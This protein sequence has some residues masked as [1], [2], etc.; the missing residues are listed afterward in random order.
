MKKLFSFV[1]VLCLCAYAWAYDFQVDGLYYTIIN[2]AEEPYSVALTDPSN[3]SEYQNM[4]ELVIPEIVEYESKT[5]SVTRIDARAF[6][7]C[8]NLQTVSVPESIV[9]CGSG[10]FAECPNLTTVYWNATHCRYASNAFQGCEK[11]QS[12]E[13]GD[14]VEVLPYK[15]CSY[16]PALTTI[17]IPESVHS[18]NSDVF[19]YC[20]GLTEINWNA[21]KIDGRNYNRIFVECNNVASIDFGNT[22]EM[23]PNYL[24]YNMSKLQEVLLPK[25]IKRIG[26]Y[27][28]CYCTNLA[29]VFI[30]SSTKLE[31]IAPYAFDGTAWLENYPEGPM[32]IGTVLYKNKITNSRDFGFEVKAGTTY[33]TPYAFAQNYGLYEISLPASLAVLGDTALNITP[34][35]VFSGCYDLIA[36][37]VHEDNAHFTSV[38]GNLYT[39]D[40]EQLLYVPE[41]S[42]KPVVSVTV[43][44]DMVVTYRD[45]INHMKL[46]SVLVDE[47]HSRYSSK[48]GILYDAT[49]DTLIYCP[50]QHKNPT[51]AAGTKVIGEYA[52]YNNNHFSTIE[53]PGSVTTIGRYAFAA[54]YGL[55]DITIPENVHT[56]QD[57]FNSCDS[58]TTIVYNAKKPSGDRYEGIRNP[59]GLYTYRNSVTSFTIGNSVEVI[60]TY[61]CQ[62]MSK[63]T[64]VAIPNSVKTI[65]DGAFY[66]CDGL[67]SF[68]IPES[69]TEIQGYIFYGRYPNY[70]LRENFINK[71]A[72][73]AEMYNYWGARI[74]DGE[75]VNGLIIE[76]DIVVDCMPRI[77]EIVI[78][79]HVKG[80]AERALSSY[81]AGGPIRGLRV[82][83]GNPWLDSR[84]D[85]NAVIET[86]TNRL[87]Y[88]MDLSTVP[89]GVEIIGSWAFS[90]SG[91][92]SLQLPN[93]VKVIEE[94]AFWNCSMLKA[95]ELPESLEMIGDEA[96]YSCQELTAIAIP[97]KAFVGNSAFCHC[98]RLQSVSI[99]EGVTSIG[100]GA[101][102]ECTNLTSITFPSTLT[103]LGGHVLEY[104][105]CQSVTCLAVNP[106]RLY[107]RL[108]ISYD[109]QP[110]LYVPCE[111]V[112]AYREGPAWVESFGGWFWDEECNCEQRGRIRCIE[113]QTADTSEVTVEA[114]YNEATFTWPKYD[115]AAS[116]TLAIDQA[117]ANVITLVF[118]A[119]GT[120][121]SMKKAAAAVGGGYAYTV[122][123]LQD[124][125]SYGYTIAV[126]DAGG[127][128][129]GNFEGEFQTLPNPANQ[130][131]TLAFNY[132]EKYGQVVGAGSYPYGTSV[133]VDLIPNEYCYLYDWDSDLSVYSVDNT[134]ISNQ[135]YSLVTLTQDTVF[136]V[137]FRPYN[138]RV[139]VNFD[140]DLGYVLGAG[141]YAHGE[142]VTLIAVAEEGSEFSRWSN[143]VTE[144]P[145]TFNVYNYT[146]ITAEFVAKG[147]GVEN[148]LDSNMQDN[149]QKILHNGQIYI[150]R[151]GQLYTIMGQKL[152]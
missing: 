113:M 16:L 22:V 97:G 43:S 136:D 110:T 111:A 28:F 1:S 17:T 71:S 114:S 144:N 143:G 9:E 61:L 120:L 150:F 38:D 138:C 135:G 62:Y 141:L 112:D 2:D 51:I 108:E 65:M 96:F 24:C 107:G 50:R 90:N 88:G 98:S 146:E 39:K 48:D 20:E 99:A 41:R 147:S 67:T 66:E 55:K 11:L 118:E 134:A 95:I 123:Q 19:A 60:P 42:E 3:K 83:E 105:N 78:P 119:N 129:L 73:D 72:L 140:K 104:T 76:N 44:K 12:F 77:T 117:D 132:D 69:V 25:S 4:T 47:G 124:G 35:S 82:E 131:V 94:G 148:V 29:D 142:E 59:F 10:I 13:F 68:T 84:N 85:C 103:E 125:V 122:T 15:L 23:V 37:H 93:T 5:Y 75:I 54:C 32:Y 92:V 130:M 49:G 151:D 106:P 64:S 52:F 145:Y 34:Q 45:L 121:S 152:N 127:Q 53:I 89:E 79:K 27:A 57:A 133:I 101:F 115:A 40:K 86:A 70:F 128:V 7:G 26:S 100:H 80:V 8:K 56:M 109:V 6:R 81:N 46:E 31:A 74:V 36:I 18:T 30:P 126:T 58:L 116:Y 87:V 102:A 139:L 91:V 63:L 14:K 149:I 33:I 21:K 137:D